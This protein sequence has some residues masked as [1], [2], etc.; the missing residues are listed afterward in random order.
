MSAK[1][2]MAGLQR[3]RT[4]QDSGGGH[5]L[6]ATADGGWRPT[7]AVRVSVGYMTAP[8][9]ATARL[10]G[11][12]RRHFLDQTDSHPNSGSRTKKVQHDNATTGAFSASNRGHD[13][14]G[15][16]G[17]DKEDAEK[18]GQLSRSSQPQHSIFLH[19]IYVYPIKSCAGTALCTQPFDSVLHSLF[20]ELYPLLAIRNYYFFVILM[21]FS[22]ICC[23]FQDL[24]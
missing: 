19:S 17:S 18:R 10:V 22:T 2:V 15:H 23:V 24:K 16:N 12:L 6:A 1:D 5:D 11:F 20:S 7:G 4:C 9:P 21:C 3:G 14:G 13:K 8:G